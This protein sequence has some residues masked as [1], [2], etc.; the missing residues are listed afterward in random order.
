MSE[1]SSKQSETIETIRTW[2]ILFL[3]VLGILSYGIVTYVTVG[4]EG[5]PGWRYGAVKDVP[6]ESP[7]AMEPMK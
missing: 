2:L 1:K 6:G 3:I 7:F 5:P 4:D